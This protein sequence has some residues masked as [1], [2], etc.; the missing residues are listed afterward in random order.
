VDVK[1]EGIKILADSIT[2]LPKIL[3]N[4]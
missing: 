1:E 3:A 2:E 4:A